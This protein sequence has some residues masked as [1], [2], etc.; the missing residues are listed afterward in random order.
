MDKL[1]YYEAHADVGKDGFVMG[2]YGNFV[3]LD[4]LANFINSVLKEI[5]I[6]YN[7]EEIANEIKNCPRDEY[8][9][10]Y[11]HNNNWVEIKCKLITIKFNDKDY[12]V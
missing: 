3:S 11:S 2:H 6:C 12:E 10:K 7:N 1:E 5:H 8:K 4:N 9:V